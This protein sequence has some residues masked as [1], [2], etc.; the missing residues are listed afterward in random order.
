MYK[1]KYLK[2]KNK[3][4][5]EKMLTGGS[6]LEKIR[7][8]AHETIRVPSEETRMRIHDRG[9]P[10]TM[11][12]A[13]NTTGSQMSEDQGS[14]ALEDEAVRPA[15]TTE[16][17]VARLGE[18]SEAITQFYE[19]SPGQ[20][21]NAVA[22][23]ENLLPPP[24]PPSLLQQQHLQ[25]YPITGIPYASQEERNRDNEFQ[26]PQYTRHETSSEPE[27]HQIREIQSISNGDALV[28]SHNFPI[29]PLNDSVT[30]SSLGRVDIAHT[31]QVD[32]VNT[33]NDLPYLAEESDKS[34][35]TSDDLSP[36]SPPSLRVVQPQQPDAAS[37]RDTT[38]SGNGAVIPT[39][40]SISQEIRVGTRNE[41]SGSSS[42][43]ILPSQRTERETFALSGAS[44][45]VESKIQGPSVALERDDRTA[46]TR[47]H[48]RTTL[49]E[50]Y[51]SYNSVDNSA[52]ESA[53][54]L[55]TQQLGQ[56]LTALKPSAATRP[57]VT[58]VNTNADH[59]IRRASIFSRGLGNPPPVLATEVIPATDVSQMGL[60]V[61]LGSH[62]DDSADSDEDADE[63]AVTLDDSTQTQ[64]PS[65]TARQ[66][67][68]DATGQVEVNAIGSI[69]SARNLSQ[70]V[71]GNVTSS[72]LVNSHN[73]DEDSDDFD[74]DLSWSTQLPQFMTATTAQLNRDLESA[75]GFD[76]PHDQ[77]NVTP[78]SSPDK[79]SSILLPSPRAEGLL[80][81][82]P[83][84]TTTAIT[85][86]QVSGGLQSTSYDATDL[87]EV[88]VSG[89]RR[90][91][92]GSDQLGVQ[93]DVSNA[94]D[95][96]FEISPMSTESSDLSKNDDIT[97]DIY[98]ILMNVTSEDDAEDDEGDDERD[99]VEK[100]K[101][102]G[103]KADNIIKFDFLCK[104]YKSDAY[105]TYDNNYQYRS[106]LTETYI[107]KCA[108]HRIPLSYL[109]NLRLIRKIL[110][111]KCKKH[112]MMF[113]SDE[114]G[115]KINT[116]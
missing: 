19:Q 100:Q 30:L 55:R 101:Y 4:L 107:S 34:S 22:V 63:S 109:I 67:L 20:A 9:I 59:T 2:Y 87:A 6:N 48:L 38:I 45:V 26:R 58:T 46:I 3:Y 65:L 40:L 5:L 62:E 61:L 83:K 15:S 79:S 91:A 71:P 25:H 104:V 17:T 29:I 76:Q 11:A 82:Q 49:G 16:M 88:S 84:L 35:E 18:L 27:V 102:E 23:S 12:T 50:P 116:E 112:H 85:E 78:S 111:D 73:S 39:D 103:I 114:F 57:Q 72:S 113:N 69:R 106:G 68:P 108:Q 77:G 75:R 66:Q 56:R 115:I 93:D 105:T 90:S 37:L 98:K 14:P 60:P 8:Y 21:M 24:P 92:G 44:G 81:H 94:D 41:S 70:I 110:I 51:K 99:D 89:S 42:V 64:H 32:D 96:V 36:I 74:D 95:A 31:G 33:R 52:D 54:L 1:T 47:P 28:R 7:R 53:N 86:A 43:S 80:E 13:S 97:F 10:K